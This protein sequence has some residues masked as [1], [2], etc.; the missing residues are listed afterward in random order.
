MFSRRDISVNI[1]LGQR[2][3]SVNVIF[4][5]RD[6]SVNIT[7]HNQKLKLGQNHKNQIVTKLKKLNGDK[8]QKIQIVTVVVVTFFCSKNN[9]STHQLMRFSGQIFAILAMFVSEK[10]KLL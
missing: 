5:Q 2:D 1:I 8:T 6:I 9:L 7:F 10:E 3:I 4:S